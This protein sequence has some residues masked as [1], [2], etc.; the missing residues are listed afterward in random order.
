[1]SHVPFNPLDPTPAEYE[2]RQTEYRDAVA[3]NRPMPSLK[4]VLITAGVI[5][6]TLGVVAILLRL[7]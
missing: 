5:A 7:L 6:A 1:M 4:R 2:A 3:G